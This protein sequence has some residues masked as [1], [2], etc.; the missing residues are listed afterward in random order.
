M[1]SYKVLIIYLL[2]K[3]VTTRND[4]RM[5]TGPLTAANYEIY[6]PEYEHIP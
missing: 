5:L 6:V 4:V 3:Y 1:L 2:T